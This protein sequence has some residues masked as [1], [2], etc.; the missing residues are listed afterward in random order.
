MDQQLPLIKL[1]N[2]SKEY[3]LGDATVMALDDISL[4]INKGEFISILGKSGSGKSTLMHIIGLL[5]HPT[6]GELHFENN[7]VSSLTD[8][9]LAAI[10]ADKIG[11]VFQSFNLLARTSALKNVLLPTSYS[12]RKNDLVGDAKR[13]LKMVGLEDRMGN[14]PAQL[15]GGQQQRVAIARALIN[16]PS[17]VLADEPT[18][19]LDSKSGREILKL[20]NQLHEEGRTVVIVTHDESISLVT[21]RVIKIIDGKLVEDR[22]QVPKEIDNAY[23]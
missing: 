4:S 16:E 10:R 12:K 9:Q 19:N 3:K 8:N 6:S 20:L 13:L 18:G 14:T 22:H 23:N 1:N 2:V 17:I 11:F 15:S 21:D 7:L 5:D